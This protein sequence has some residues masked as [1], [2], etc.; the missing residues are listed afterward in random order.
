MKKTFGLPFLFFVLC[1]IANAQAHLHNSGTLFISTGADTLYINGNFTNTN[2][3]AFTNNGKLFVTQNLTND[4]AAMPAGSGTL[5]LNGTLAQTLSG[6]QL[7]KT[8]QLVSNNPSGITL[9]NN[10]SI[11]D[12][13]TFVAGIITTSATPSYLI[14]E[15][16]SS[17]TG[18]SD[19][20][21]VSGW[22][23]KMGSSDFVFPVGNGTVQRTIAINSLSAGSEFNAK[24]FAATPN[25]TQTQFP[26]VDV[27]RNEYWSLTKTSGG[28]AKVTMNWDHSKVFFP[29]WIVPDISTAGYNGS[30]WADGGGAAS[31]DVATTGTI[32]SN[33]ISSFNLFTFGSKSYVVPLTLLHF[34]A[35]RQGNA[36]QINWT[37]DNEYNVDRFIVEKSE[38]GIFFYSIAQTPA[39]NSGTKEYYSIADN[40]A[41]HSIAFYRLRLIDIDGKENCSR[42]VSVRTRNQNNLVS[43]LVNP[44]RNQLILA[45]PNQ[46]SGLFN[47]RINST[48][49]QL[50]QQGILVVENGGQYTIPLKGKP[51]AGLYILELTV[52]QQQYFQKFIIQ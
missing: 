4:E 34:T 8:Y 25:P 6:S 28:T 48:N 23:K 39:R 44:V 13:H 31:G 46:L 29:N 12:V 21:H 10:L 52:F 43:L 51:A 11:S 17:Y 9:N 47:Y 35:S 14:Y 40:G 2:S 42:I 24:Y 16:G 36:T 32:T 50:I 41:I 22:V 1:S 30:V 3:A 33:S 27:D 19:A 49:G 5:F 18:I 15:S 38:D 26:V 45:A 20:R 7:F 37:T